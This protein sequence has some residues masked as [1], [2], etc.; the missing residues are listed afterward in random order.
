MGDIGYRFFSSDF[1]V[2]TVNIF[3]MLTGVKTAHIVVGDFDK[4]ETEIE[5]ANIYLDIAHVKPGKR[6]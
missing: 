3:Q 1:M 6:K 2:N 5:E 4:Q